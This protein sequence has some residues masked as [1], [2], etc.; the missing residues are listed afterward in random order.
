MEVVDLTQHLSHV[1]ASVLRS[2]ATEVISHIGLRGELENRG[3]R[4]LFVP[5]ALQE[6]QKKITYDSIV[7]EKVHLLMTEGLT[8]LSDE[9]NAEQLREDVISQYQNKREGLDPNYRTEM[10]QEGESSELDTMTDLQNIIHPK[11]VTRTLQ[12][13]YRSSQNGDMP[14]VRTLRNGQSG[15]SPGHDSSEKY[16]SDD[17]GPE[18]IIL[19]TTNG[20]KAVVTHQTLQETLEE[21]QLALT[22]TVK[23]DRAQGVRTPLASDQVALGLRSKRPGLVSL[24]LQSQYRETLDAAL[25]SAVDELD[26]ELRHRFEQLFQM[27]VMA[28]LHLYAAACVGDITLKQNQEAFIGGYFRREAIPQFAETARRE[29]LIRKGPFPGDKARLRDTEFLEE[30]CGPI[31]PKT[32]TEVQAAVMKLARKQNIAAPDAEQI[33]MIKRET[34]KQKGRAIRKMSR[35]SDVLQNLIWILFARASEGL[36]MSSGR[37]TSR[38]IEQYKLF[39]NFENWQKLVKWRDLLKGENAEP[40]DLQGMKELAIKVLREMDIP[41]GVDDAEALTD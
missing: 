4:I 33:N 10:R 36:F 41:V 37:D 6:E 15:S 20:M 11:S 5:A 22:S 35:G 29:G 38:M 39:E 31:V 18:L 34:L 2:S 30:T 26:H 8:I 13:H 7:Q 23:A 14:G 9:D 17:T 3:D 25:A 24:L 28:P 12:Q 32:L 16:H 40:E 21:S 27:T 19:E 1:P